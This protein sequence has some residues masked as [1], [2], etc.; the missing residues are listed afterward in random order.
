MIQKQGTI[1]FMHEDNGVAPRGLWWSDCPYIK[2]LLDV[3]SY[4]FYKGW[5]NSSEPLFEWFVV[6]N[7]NDVFC[8]ISASIFIWALRRTPYKTSIVIN[9]HIVPALIVNLSSHWVLHSFPTPH[10]VVSAFLCSHLFLRLRIFLF[11]FPY[12]LRKIFCLVINRHTECKN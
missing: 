10:I 12:Y 11:Q 6:S 9:V 5:C 7:F 1:L 8:G 2:H 3:L 4:F